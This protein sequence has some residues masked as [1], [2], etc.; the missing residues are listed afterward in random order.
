MGFIP[1]YVV[2]TFGH[3]T[4]YKVPSSY[5]IDFANPDTMTAVELDG[6]SHVAMNKS[7][8]DNK[9]TQVLQSLGWNVI[10]VKHGKEVTQAHLSHVNQE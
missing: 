7:D 8:L 4:D 3:N 9:K 2:K 6:A 1:E 5:K 10:R